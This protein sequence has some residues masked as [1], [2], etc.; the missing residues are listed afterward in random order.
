MPEDA[1][2]AADNLLRKRAA[3]KGFS[4]TILTAPLG[5][6]TTSGAVAAKSLLG[7]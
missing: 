2:V 7:G 4:S 1:K 5:A 3:A 6:S